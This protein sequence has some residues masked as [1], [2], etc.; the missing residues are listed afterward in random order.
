MQLDPRFP[1][2]DLYATALIIALG[3]II[4]AFFMGGV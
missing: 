1:Y 2:D 3:A 4:V